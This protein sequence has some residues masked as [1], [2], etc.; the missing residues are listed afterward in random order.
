MLG[1]DAGVV[2]Q[3]CIDGMTEHKAEIGFPGEGA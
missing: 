1:L 2:M 3:A